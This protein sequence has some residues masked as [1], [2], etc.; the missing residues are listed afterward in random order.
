MEDP[1]GN[2]HPK[3]ATAIAG[4]IARSTRMDI[5]DWAVTQADAARTPHR[6]EGGAFMIADMMCVSEG[7]EPRLKQSGADRFRRWLTYLLW[8]SGDMSIRTINGS[9]IEPQDLR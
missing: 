5:E 3:T 1:T 7:L 9:I 8:V 6:L 2:T 4:W